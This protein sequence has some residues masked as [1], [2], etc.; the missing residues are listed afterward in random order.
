MAERGHIMAVV[1]N[2][3][4]R[5]FPVELLATDFGELVLLALVL[6]IQ[7]VGQSVTLTSCELLELMVGLS[8]VIHHSPPKLL[9]FVAGRLLGCQL[10][11]LNFSQAVFRGFL[12]E[13]LVGSAQLS[14]ARPAR[15]FLQ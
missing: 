2:H 7:V 12:D 6:G 8:M 15:R 14:R 11:Q 13:I 5:I 4:V 3:V 10:A 1:L 9:H